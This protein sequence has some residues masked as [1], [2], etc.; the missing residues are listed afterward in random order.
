MMMLKYQ[1]VFGAV[2][3][4]INL[5]VKCFIYDCCI[6]VLSQDKLVPMTFALQSS[7]VGK[8]YQRLEK[9]VTRDVCDC[10]ICEHREI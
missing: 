8:I 10:C 2:I 5:S 3:V 1:F 9:H 4:H 7:V 6:C